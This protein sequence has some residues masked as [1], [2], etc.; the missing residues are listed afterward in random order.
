MDD[1]FRREVSEVVEAL[2]ESQREKLAASGP[3]FPLAGRLGRPPRENVTPK[4]LEKLVWAATNLGSDSQ[5]VAAM[6]ELAGI[7]LSVSRS[8]G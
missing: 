1:Q 5:A 4:V 6:N 2:A 3:C 8:S 7:D